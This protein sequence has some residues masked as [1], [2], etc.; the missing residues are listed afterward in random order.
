[1]QSLSTNL[2]AR[3]LLLSLQHILLT[4]VSLSFSF[5]LRYSVYASVSYCT[6]EQLFQPFRKMRRGQGQGQVCERII[7]LSISRSPRPMCFLAESF[8][9]TADDYK[10]RHELIFFNFYVPKKICLEDTRFKFC[11]RELLNKYA[12]IYENFN[13]HKLKYYIFKFTFI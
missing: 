3:P 6:G 11:N 8:L 2:K 7:V 13:I 5:S 4:R 1:M 10:F 9:L 12:K